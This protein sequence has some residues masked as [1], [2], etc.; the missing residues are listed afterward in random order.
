MRDHYSKL[1]EAMAAAV[2]ADLDDCNAQRFRT[3]SIGTKYERAATDNA[4]HHY[5]QMKVAMF[6]V[7]LAWDSFSATAETLAED[8]DKA[9]PGSAGKLMAFLPKKEAA[10]G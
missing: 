7:F 1:K 9:V 2:K 10:H 5:H 8:L 3:T 6:R 4:L